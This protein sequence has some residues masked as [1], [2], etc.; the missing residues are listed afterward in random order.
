MKLYWVERE[1]FVITSANLSQSALGDTIQEEIGIFCDEPSQVPID[2]IVDRL[3]SR[4]LEAAELR[5]LQQL[6][7]E[8]WANVP[9]RNLNAPARRIPEF[10]EWYENGRSPQWK[11]GWFDTN[12]DESPSTTRAA[13]D[14]HGV[15]V[16]EDFIPCSPGQLAANDWV[17][18]FRLDEDDRVSDPGWLRVD[19]I[20]NLTRSE[21][22]KSGYRQEAVQLRPLGAEHR[23]PFRIELPALRKAVAAIGPAHIRAARRLDPS[24]QFIT[25]LMRETSARV[26][27]RGRRAGA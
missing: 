11:I 6:H 18:C 2:T 21:V 23:P 13:R 3:K 14:M 1:G 12:G 22:R 9:R 17:L 26:G 7:D 16:I 8:Y 4:P 27:R 5:Q 20:K 19:F 24:D 25:L 15:G 10:A